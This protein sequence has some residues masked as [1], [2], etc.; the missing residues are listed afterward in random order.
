MDASATADGR[1]VRGIRTATAVYFFISGF[2]YT[3]WASRIPAIQQQLHLNDAQLGAALFALPV[4]L[5]LTLPITSSLLRVY[6]SSRIMLFGAMVFNVML[7]L[8]GYVAFYWQLLLVLLCFGSSRNLLNLSINTESVG[9]QALYKRSIITTFHGIWS[10]AGFGGSALGYLAVSL[11]IVPS[12]HL[13]T[14]SSTLI[15]LALYFYPKTLKQAPLAVE[16]KPIFSLPDKYLLKYALI[17]FASMACENIMY[18]WGEIYMQKAASA[19]H[20]TAIAAFVVF[21]VF[22]TIGRFAGDPLVNRYGVKAPMRYSGVLVIAGLSLAVL[23]PYVPVVIT[24][25]ALIGLGVSCIVPLVYRQ[26]GRS[27]TMQGGAAVAA[28]STIGY[29]GFLVVPPMV[30]FIAQVA[31][32]RWAFGIFISLGMLM[33]WMTRK[34]EA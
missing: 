28:V 19:S 17:C 23:F 10:L 12:W 31:N 18:D 25:F 7:G 27:T 5:L 16:S 15:I 30:G 4:G 24:A 3:T 22:V 1:S 34:I 14:V 26:A 8:L 2:G 21:M 20:A 6:S 11:N 9:V 33:V 32:M 13:L 29:L